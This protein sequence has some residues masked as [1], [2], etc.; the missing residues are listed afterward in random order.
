M[1]GFSDQSLRKYKIRESEGE[2]INGDNREIISTNTLL[3]DDCAIGVT[4]VE[5]KH[6]F[7]VDLGN[8]FYVIDLENF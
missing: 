2:G 7:V 3:L 1:I 8:N 6:L 5:E 4:K